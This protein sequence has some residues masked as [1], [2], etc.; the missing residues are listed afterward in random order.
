MQKAWINDEG[1]VKWFCEVF[2]KNCG[3][4]R[5]Q[6][7]IVDQH[8]S[9]EAIDLLEEACKEDIYLTTTHYTCIMPLRQRH[10]WN[11]EKAL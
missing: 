8:V 7:L 1:C 3:N 5:P 10:F 4:A 9:H 11:S 6:L 2:L